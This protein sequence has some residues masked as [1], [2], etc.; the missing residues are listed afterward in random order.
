MSA[1]K[2]IRINSVV[3]LDQRLRN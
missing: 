3:T 1:D 2:L